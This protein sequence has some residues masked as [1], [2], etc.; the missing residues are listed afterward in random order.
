METQKT[1]TTGQKKQL[2]KLLQYDEQAK[3][4]V[5]MSFTGHPGK[6]RLSDLSF[7]QANE[8]IR[9]LGGKTAV[10]Y[11]WGQFDKFN[12]QHSYVLSLCIQLGWSTNHPRYGYVADLNR[13]SDWLKGS[14]SPV[15]KPLR[16]M[17]KEECSKVI[18]ALEQ[19][20]IKKHQK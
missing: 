2:M 13:L 4:E 18:S 1:I 20:T 11:Q 16:S 9:K 19:M 12:G 8:A 17:T 3:E 10:D 7:E 6:T 14:R 15:Q 5:V